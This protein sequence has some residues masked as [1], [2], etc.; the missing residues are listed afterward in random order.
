MKWVRIPICESHE[1]GNDIEILQPIHSW[2]DYNVAGNAFQDS[3]VLGRDHV[4]H[5]ERP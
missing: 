3:V 4:L 1:I 2:I 5:E